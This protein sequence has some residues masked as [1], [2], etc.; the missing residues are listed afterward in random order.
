MQLR[1]A[2]DCYHWPDESLQV[3]AN[4]LMH[5]PLSPNKSIP[6]A[7]PWNECGTELSLYVHVTSSAFLGDF[8]HLILQ[9]PM[10]LS[11]S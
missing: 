6:N 7:A 5:T 3:R 4:G 10:K 2:A 8:K 9:E 1:F 11:L